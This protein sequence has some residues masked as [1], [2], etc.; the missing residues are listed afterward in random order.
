[1]GQRRHS[2]NHN[3][4][5]VTCLKRDVM[6]PA[7][8]GQGKNTNSATDARE[9]AMGNKEEN[10]KATLE[11]TPLGQAFTI[12][13]Y[14]R[15]YIVRIPGKPDFIGTAAPGY[16]GSPYHY[17][18]EDLLVASLSAC[19]M[20]TYLAYAAGSKVHVVSYQDEADGILAL[21]G[22]IMKFREVT[23]RPKIKITK[24]SSLDKARELHDRAHHA[25]FIANSV[26]FPI[27]IE[28]QFEVE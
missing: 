26:N 3:L 20:L 6:I 18:P 2:T 24:D 22:K 12:K 17:N 8:V 28:P 10:F 19:H 25:C 16:M 21:D 4:S 9:S 27:K 14:A 23:L 11:W 13:E 1:M 7:R 15:Q 5:N